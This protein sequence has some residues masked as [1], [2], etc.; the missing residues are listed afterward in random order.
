MVT[1]SPSGHSISW[2]HLNG[3][4]NDKN[5]NEMNCQFIDLPQQVKIGHHLEHGPGDDLIASGGG[6]RAVVAVEG[7][8]LDG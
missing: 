2:P 6:E 3:D 4:E 1:P 7:V 5:Y 8:P